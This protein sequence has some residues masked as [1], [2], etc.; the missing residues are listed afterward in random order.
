MTVLC[1]KLFLKRKKSF[2]IEKMFTNLHVEVLT[3]K[4]NNK[5]VLYID[6]LKDVS[7]CL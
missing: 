1:L 5:S 4:S 2:F 6:K 3:T 7:K